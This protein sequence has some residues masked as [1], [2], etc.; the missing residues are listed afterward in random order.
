MTEVTPFK[1]GNVSLAGFDAPEMI[2]DF[3]SKQKI[4]LNEY[5]GGLMTAQMLGRFPK[6][7]TFRQTLRG[8]TA[9]AKANEVDQLTKAGAIT[10][11]WAG[12][13]FYGLVEDVHIEPKSNIE[14]DYV[15]IFI[16]VQRDEPQS[17]AATMSGQ[18][19]LNNAANVGNQQA[20]APASQYA[21]PPSI[22]SATNQLQQSIKQALNN[23]QNN[24]ANVPAG[25]INSLQQ[26][27]TGIKQQLAPLLDS[28]DSQ[29]VSAAADL[30]TTMTAIRLALQQTVPLQEQINTQDPDLFFL[31]AKYYDDPSKFYLIAGANELFDA[32]PSGQFQL[33]V[34]KDPNITPARPPTLL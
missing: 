24:L 14:I 26:Q 8:A 18:D 25:T 21:F 4:A 33:S 23:N 17:G 32:Q 5:T 12:Y 22:P 29:A 3:G 30:N 1:V 19:M 2:A 7:I 34:P 20:N 15:C 28:S 31:A 13:S 9:Q 16:P 6:S 10:L 27:V 11:S